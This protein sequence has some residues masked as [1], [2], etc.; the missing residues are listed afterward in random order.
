MTNVA[1]TV[2]INGV[3]YPTDDLSDKAVSLINLLLDL[4]KKKSDLVQ[5][6]DIISAAEA[7]FNEILNAELG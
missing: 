7:K 1:D 3:S 2:E 6:I 4:R 5:E